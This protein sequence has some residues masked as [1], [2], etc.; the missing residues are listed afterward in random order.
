[1]LFNLFLH[2]FLGGAKF[3]LIQKYARLVKSVHYSVQAKWSQVSYA[4]AKLGIVEMYVAHVS[5]VL[6]RQLK[7]RVV[8]HC[9]MQIAAQ[10]YMWLTGS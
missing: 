10:D 6:L 4:S 9:W 8:S 5:P 1:M 7:L 3:M 2:K